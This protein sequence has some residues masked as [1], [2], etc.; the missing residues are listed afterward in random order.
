MIGIRK[1]NKGEIPARKVC[2]AC[3]GNQTKYNDKNP[4]PGCYAIKNKGET[5]A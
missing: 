5:Y 2:Q 1:V 4:I 3:G